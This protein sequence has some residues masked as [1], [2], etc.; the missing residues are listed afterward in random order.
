MRQKELE[1]KL[2]IKNTVIS[3]QIKVLDEYRGT[4]KQLNAQIKE[5]EFR[6]SEHEKPV[7][8]EDL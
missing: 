6:L 3:E 4:I 8:I 7:F 2:K 1:H 5:L